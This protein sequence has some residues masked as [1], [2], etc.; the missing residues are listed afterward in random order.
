M[1]T[2]WENIQKAREVWPP[3]IP[4]ILAYYDKAI[5]ERPDY[6]LTYKDKAR[7]Y[8]VLGDM[9]KSEENYKLWREIEAKNN[10]KVNLDTKLIQ[11]RDESIT[12]E[13]RIRK[14]GSYHKIHPW[15]KLK[16]Y[17]DKNNEK[18]RLDKSDEKIMAKKKGELVEEAKKIQA[19]LDELNS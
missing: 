16:E 17:Y 4:K 2:A 8:F 15:E 7:L 19:E 9:E 11:M 14:K 12:N 3:N 6:P 13:L 10:K 18:N 1:N 5:K